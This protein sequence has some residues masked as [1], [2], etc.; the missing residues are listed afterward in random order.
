MNIKKLALVPAMQTKHNIYFSK[1][2]IIII[3]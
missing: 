2:I 1:N 3:F